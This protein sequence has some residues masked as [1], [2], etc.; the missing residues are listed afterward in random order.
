MSRVGIGLLGL[1]LIGGKHLATMRACADVDIVGVVD[2]APKAREAAEKQGIRCFAAREELLAT[3][4]LSAIIVATPNQLHAED[5]VACIERGL[6]ILVEKPVAD[7]VANGERILAAQRRP[8]RP[9]SS[10]TIAGTT[11]LFR[12]RARSCAPGKSGGSPPCSASRSS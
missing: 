1:G 6:P 12:R 8:A 3:P 2:P 5:A 4:G 11:R 10:G 9:F 7:T